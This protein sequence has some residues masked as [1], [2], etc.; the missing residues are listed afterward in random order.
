MKS[1]SD[2]NDTKSISSDELLQ[3]ADK[4]LA[5][6]DSNQFHQ[7]MAD[8]RQLYIKEKYPMGEYRVIIA[9]GRHFNDY[10]LLQERCLYYL[11]EK[12]KTHRVII[13]S[14]HASGADTLGERFAEEHNLPCELHPANWSRH[15]RAAGP[16]RNAEMAGVADALIAFWDGK[17]RGTANMIRL[18]QEKGLKVIVVQYQEPESNL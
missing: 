17:S 1:N 2:M 18:G 13:V 16:I 11:S 12:L 3:R 10:E 14:G 15:G 6:Y 7:H 5:E 4:S 8:Y 9:G